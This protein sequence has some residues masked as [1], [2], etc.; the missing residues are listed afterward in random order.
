[1]KSL[2]SFI[3]FVLAEFIYGQNLTNRIPFYENGMYGICDTNFTIIVPAKFSMTSTYE[4]GFSKVGLEQGHNTVYNFIDV[5]GKELCTEYMSS[6]PGDFIN[7]NAVINRHGQSAIIDTSGNLILPFKYVRAN[8]FKEGLATVACGFWKWGVVNTNGEEIIP[9]IYDGIGYYFLE[10]IN[11]VKQNGK[12]A[13]ISKTGNVFT[14]FEFD[15]IGEQSFASLTIY[16]GIIPAKRFGKWGYINNIGEEIIPYYYCFASQFRN[17]YCVA[18]IDS[19]FG[20]L[21]FKGDTVVPFVY[22]YIDIMS[23][24]IYP[25]MKNGKFGFINSRN[26]TIIPFDYEYSEGFNEGLAFACKNRKCGFINY[27]NQIVIPFQFEE[28]NYIKFWD[29]IA[30]VNHEG[31][32]CYIDKSGKI[33][34]R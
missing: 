4:F 5:N 34:K 14:P 19:L 17:N 24:S 12:W 25:A 18:S 6:L 3:F 11:R 15:E 28:E 7:G 13:L 20:M 33:Y 30:L 32:W 26:E 22:E 31:T 21:N 8:S 23:D 16:N 2:I 1:M 29:G 10:G 27:S 9:C